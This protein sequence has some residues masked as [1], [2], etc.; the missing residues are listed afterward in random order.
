MGV[1]PA[2]LLHFAAFAASA[3]VK[4]PT[5]DQPVPFEITWD[6]PRDQEVLVGRPGVGPAGTAGGG[7]GAAAT[8]TTLHCQLKGKPTFH[9]GDAQAAL[10][11]WRAGGRAPLHAKE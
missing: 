11:L 5:S 4:L 7:P 6:D 3:L 9:D 2:T 8:P 1:R 10:V